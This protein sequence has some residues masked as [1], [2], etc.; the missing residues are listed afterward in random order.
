MI[1]VI[2]TTKRQE[3]YGINSYELA[4][5]GGG[6]LPSYSAGAHIDVHLPG[7]RI[8]QYS[9]VTPAADG[10]CYTIAV[11]KEPESRGGSL[12]MHEQVSLGTRLQI[13]APRNHFELVPDASHSILF[14]GGIGVTPIICMAEELAVQGA[15]F[16]MHYCARS[17]DRAAFVDRIRAAGFAHQVR[18]HFDDEAPE[19]RL[20]AERAL[21][22][23]KENTHLYVCGP[24]GFMDYV[25]DTAKKMRW[26]SARIHSEY[27]TG[28]APG[29]EGDTSFK[30]KIA[31]SGAIFDVPIGKTVLAVL[32]K[33]GI[34]IPM[35]CE[36][37]VCG[38][39]LTGVLEGEPDHRDAV[40]GDEE[41]A[42]NNQFTPCCSRAKTPLLVLDL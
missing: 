22:C 42:L 1:E 41:R 36:K 26:P 28:D 16:T 9:L 2:V 18:F 38:T 33:H 30:V 17:R 24:R 35:S 10:K 14:A 3:A 11:L 4:E 27:F 23:A 8:R 29:S 34:E 25:I 5:S 6:T 13:S 37:G 19:Q 7:G 21:A 32:E 15:N 31:S 40:L 20:S 39:C 12:A